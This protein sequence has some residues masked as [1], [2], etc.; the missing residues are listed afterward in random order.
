MT[1]QLLGG[2]VAVWVV[3][4]LG[5]GVLL[6]R[7]IC[8]ARGADEAPATAEAAYLP[9]QRDEAP[10]VLDLTDPG[11]GLPLPRAQSD[12]DHAGAQQRHG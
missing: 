2:V 4:A 11:P 10:L 5:L 9:G 1:L 7:A 6:C 3:A 12:P 8:W